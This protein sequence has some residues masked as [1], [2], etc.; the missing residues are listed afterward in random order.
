MYTDLQGDVIVDRLVAIEMI[1]GEVSVAYF[2]RDPKKDFSLLDLAK[3]LHK[4]VNVEYT[5]VV[6]Q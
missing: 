5:E 3:H 4:I 2:T 6:K 1:C